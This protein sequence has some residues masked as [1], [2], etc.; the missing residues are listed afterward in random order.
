MW[1]MAANPWQRGEVGLGECLRDQPHLPVVFELLAVSRGDP[2]ALLAA[3]L[4]GVQPEVGDARDVLA[5][6]EDAEDA[7]GLARAVGDVGEKLVVG[8]RRRRLLLRLL[9]RQQSACYAHADPN[10]STSRRATN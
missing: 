7:T 9:V 4:Q 3:V 6:R 1:P 5:R 10:P 2:G 8:H